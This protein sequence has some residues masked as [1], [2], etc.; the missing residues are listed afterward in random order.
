[1]FYQ[2]FKLLFVTQQNRNLRDFLP[3]KVVRKKMESTQQGGNNAFP[4]ILYLFC[5]SYNKHKA[6]ADLLQPA[7]L[8]T[9]E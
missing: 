6:E 9:R 1:M 2:V 7:D 8:S 3:R 5:I 4:Q